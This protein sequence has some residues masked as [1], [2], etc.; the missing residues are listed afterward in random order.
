MCAVAYGDVGYGGGSGP[1]PGS[2]VPGVVRIVVADG[3]PLYRRGL[4]VL[5]ASRPGWA[6]VAQEDTGAGTLTAALRTD[7]DLVV[8]DIDLPHP[9]AAETTRRIAGELRDVGIL[10]LAS[11][12]DGA[13]MA[14][15]LCAG[16]RACLLK[17]DDQE[18]VV[19]AVT[20]VARGDA[21]LPASAARHV[22]AGGPELASRELE[23]LNLVAAGWS[24]EDISKVLVLDSAAVRAHVGAIVVK[25]QAAERRRAALRAEETPPPGD[26]GAVLGGPGSPR[27]TSSRRGNRRSRRR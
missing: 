15:L 19:R 4:T 21:L 9:D 14:G 13:A 1:P 5:L 20:A 2:R 25:I 27:R 8:M 11:R 6:V 22:L 16:A 7:P 3:H 24:A 26:G 10:V 23:V 17:T 18:S 12:D